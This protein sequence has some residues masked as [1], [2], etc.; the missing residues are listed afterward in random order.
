MKKEKK[1]KPRSYAS[2]LVENNDPLTKCS[3]THGGGGA[4]RATDLFH[5][6]ITFLLAEGFPNI[7]LQLSRGGE[8]LDHSTLLQVHVAADFK[9]GRCTKKLKT[10]SVFLLVNVYFCIFVFF[11][12]LYL[13]I[14]VFVLGTADFKASR[15]TKKLKTKPPAVRSYLL[16]CEIQGGRRFME[17]QQH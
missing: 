7:V 5:S 15:C 10:I 14:F 13:C 11:V 1:L 3:L 12:F 4:D 2:T 17:H 6:F 8:S 16:V 9:A